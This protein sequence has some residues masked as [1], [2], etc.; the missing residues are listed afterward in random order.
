MR[1]PSTSGIANN[2]AAFAA[3][4]AAAVQDRQRRGHACVL[5]RHPSAQEGVRLL[6]LRRRGGLARADGPDRLVGQRGPRRAPR[7]PDFSSTASSCRASTASVTPRSRSSRRLAHAEDRREPGLAGRGVLLRHRRVGVPEDG[8]ALRMAHDRVGGPELPEHRA[9]DFPRVRALLE[10]AHVLPAPCDRRA[11]EERADLR[12]VGG[13]HA[14]REMAARPAASRPSGAPEQR[15]VAGKAAVE[16]PVPDDVFLRI[17]APQNRRILRHRGIPGQFPGAPRPASALPRRLDRT[18]YFD[19]SR[20]MEV[21][22]AVAALAA[23]AH[24]TRL[25][26]FRLLVE[27]GPEGDTPGAIA[28][29]LDIAPSTLSFHL[30]ELARAG[31]VTPRRG[32]ALHLLLGQ[33]RAHGRAHDLPHPATAA[34]ACRRMPRRRSRP[35]SPPARRFRKRKIHCP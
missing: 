16:L 8:P 18:R 12:Q 1:P 17:C 14:D 31:L 5:L 7:R 2:S 10:P 9:G 11:L 22:D 15:L 19:N 34:R 4:D 32:L 27:A 24:E 13:R 20:N 6:R 29:R 26:I 30:K 23:L 3:L 25:A 28:A 35:P 33:L 21:K